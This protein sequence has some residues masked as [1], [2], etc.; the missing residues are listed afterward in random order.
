MRPGPVPRRPHLRRRPLPEPDHDRLRD[1]GAPGERPAR[2]DARVAI[3][4]EAPTAA[5]TSTRSARA[6]GWTGTALQI[7]NAGSI[8]PILES[9]LDAMVVSMVAP[10]LQRFDL[11]VHPIS[12]QDDDGDVLGF[13]RAARPARCRRRRTA[14]RYPHVISVSYG[15]CE[16]TV[17]AGHRV[18]D[19]R[20]AQAQG[21][22][23]A[24]R[25]RGRRRGRHRLVG[26]REGRPG[27]PAHHRRQAAADV[28]AGDVV[29]G[30]RGRRDQPHARREPTRS[31]RPAPGTTPPIRAPYTA[32][33][34]GGGGQSTFVKR[35]WWQPAQSFATTG[36][37]MVPDVA[38]F[39]DP[40]PGYAIVCSGAVQGWPA[41]RPGHR[42]RR[43]H[44]RRGP[45][46]R[47]DDRALD[48]AGARRA[49]R[50]RASSRRSCTRSP[51]S[52]SPHAFVD[53]TA[54]SNALF[55]GSC[56]PARPGYDL[57][58]GWGSPL[59]DVIASQLPG[60]K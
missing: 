36:N 29:V 11:W 13:L 16:S 18:T 47:G 56:C 30:A 38:A 41:R 17:A 43:R 55:G 58:T 28:L 19:D 27:Q 53:I 52:A 5:G 10:Q 39:A 45:A 23:R 9:S 6:S 59:A 3:V 21:H 54:G 40:H 31:P 7:H 22:R 48:A 12:E 26:V 4:G 1:R 20:R 8:K 37:R 60:S 51:L 42:V 34:G 14:R 25:R 57:A 15:V 24:R 32:T 2:P 33:S 50:G 44:E 46:R 35:P 49:A